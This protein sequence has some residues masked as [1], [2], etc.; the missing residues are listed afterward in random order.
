MIACNDV[1]YG[2][3]RLAT[4]GTRGCEHATGMRAKCG[5]RRRMDLISRPASDKVK[6]DQTRIKV[7]VAI[8]NK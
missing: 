1:V 6:L 3:P 4:R 7:P 5:R 2:L 8:E